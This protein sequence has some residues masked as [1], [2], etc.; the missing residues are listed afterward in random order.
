MVQ[1]EHPRG[2]R[3]RADDRALAGTGSADQAGTKRDQF[4]NVSDIVPTIYDLLGVTPPDV[5]TGV[6]QLPVTG[7][8]FASLLADADAPATNTLQYFEMAGAGRSSPSG[9]R[10]WKAVCKHNQGADY[11]TEPW[12]LYHLA[13]DW[14]ECN[15]LAE[16][17]RQARR[18]DRPVVAGGRAA[19]RAA[20]RRPHGR[21]VRRPVPTTTRRTRTTALRLPPADV[22]DARP[23]VGLD[24]WPDLRPDRSGH[25]A[26]GDEGVLC[27]T[28]TENSGC[29]VFVQNDRLVVD[30]NSFNDHT[31]V[32]SSVA[33]AGR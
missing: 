29:R 25:R 31:V 6:E 5:Y 1:A 12:E 23:G 13:D 3:A 21:A 26:A 32:E 4:V 16:R 14:S 19:R 10:W 28:G 22:A 15:D 33:G 30:Y 24:R 20:A 11:D 9:R 2:R 27:A 18:A 8:S 17:A 7:H